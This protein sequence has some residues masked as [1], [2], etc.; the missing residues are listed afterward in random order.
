[1][2]ILL[3]SVFLRLPSPY[4]SVLQCLFSDCIEK[5]V[6]IPLTAKSYYSASYQWT[7]YYI[8]I[9]GQ[10]MLSLG[11]GVCADWVWFFSSLGIK[12]PVKHTVSCYVYLPIATMPHFPR[13]S[14]ILICCLSFMCLFFMYRSYFE[15]W[16]PQV[17]IIWSQFS[18][19][20]P[21]CG[22]RAQPQNKNQK[23]VNEKGQ[24]D[25]NR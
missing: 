14:L 1:M 18:R 13:Q 20:F 7:H 10:H 2:N 3:E 24:P 22:S 6:I 21:F 15:V 9:L 11:H 12:E 25:Q 17:H 4:H 19:N 16:K 8:Y 23:T 5:D